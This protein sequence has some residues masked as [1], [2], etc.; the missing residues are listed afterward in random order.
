MFKIERLSFSSIDASQRFCQAIEKSGWSFA[1]SASSPLICLLPGNISL[2]G[3]KDKGKE[4]KMFL[5]EW[6]TEACQ[7]Q[8]S[9]YPK[10]SFSIP[11][12]QMQ[13]NDEA[14]GDARRVKTLVDATEFL[15]NYNSHVSTGTY[16]VG[17]MLLKGITIQADSTQ[18]L[19]TMLDMAARNFNGGVQ[20]GYMGFQ[21]DGKLVN[22]REATSS[23]AESSRSQQARMGTIVMALGP[24]TADEK[25]FETGLNDSSNWYIIDSTEV[26]ALVPVWEIAPFGDSEEL[27]ECRSMLLEAWQRAV[28]D[29]AP[30]NARLFDL[31][32]SS[33]IT[34]P[35]TTLNLRPAGK[36]EA[37][38]TLMSRLA[39]KEPRFQDLAT[40]LLSP[41]TAKESLLKVW[42][43]ASGG[44]TS[45]RISGFDPKVLLFELPDFQKLLLHISQSTEREMDEGKSLVRRIISDDVEVSLVRAGVSLQEPV[46]AVLQAN[47]VEDEVQDVATKLPMQRFEPAQ[48][49]VHVKNLVA[50]VDPTSAKLTADDASLGTSLVSVKAWLRQDT[51]GVV[52]K[53]IMKYGFDENGDCNVEGVT[54]E[55]VKNMT[56]EVTVALEGDQF[57]FPSTPQKGT[58]TILKSNFDA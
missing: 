48:L 35:T 57:K 11:R 29:E 19:E 45:N 50:N 58:C 27:Q 5:E 4:R 28:A 25:L 37:I 16:H 54:N 3:A 47:V 10:A 21:A 17:G 9:Y 26:A 32:Q 1:V 13:L 44:D 55:Q 6:S 22:V 2:D 38:A 31:L 56:Q 7:I 33:T 41:Q 12:H 49:P 40:P 15:R 42:I 18:R 14:I 8:C 36:S 51:N 46:K 30:R 39:I 52:R 53:I 43:E 20:F 23:S 24:Q 34:R